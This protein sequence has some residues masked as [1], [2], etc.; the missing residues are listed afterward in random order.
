MDL[1]GEIGTIRKTLDEHD[2]RLTALESMFESARGAP[3]SVSPLRQFVFQLRPANFQQ[4]LL[5]IAYHLETDAG[6]ASF[7]VRDLEAGFRDARESAPKNL[8]DAANAEVDK[9]HLM[10]AGKKDNLK[11]WVLTN[12]G[13]RYVE[14]GFQEGE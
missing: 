9:G 6:C 13:V 5:G 1:K 12:K 10:E 14:S 8:N 3:G 7:N 11:A 4:A 2:A